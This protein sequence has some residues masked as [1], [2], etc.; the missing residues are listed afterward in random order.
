MHTA[1]NQYLTSVALNTIDSNVE[2]CIEVGAL[3]EASKYDLK[4]THSIC[5]I[6]ENEFSA[7][8]VLTPCGICQERLRYWGVDVKV[9]VTTKEN[10]LKFVRLDELQPYHWTSAFEDIVMYDD[11]HIV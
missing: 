5:V 4:V 3:C 6:R 8:K 11:K 10:E 1:D 2:L 7:F 9:G